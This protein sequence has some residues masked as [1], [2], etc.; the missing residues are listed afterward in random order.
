MF[1]S[2]SHIHFDQSKKT[3]IEIRT[4]YARFEAERD[5]KIRTLNLKNIDV[6]IK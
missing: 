4:S 5:P 3:L 6:L 1:F 2:N